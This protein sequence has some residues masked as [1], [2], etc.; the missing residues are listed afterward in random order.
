ME[1]VLIKLNPQKL[2]NPDLD[3]CY[4]L[5]ERLEEITDGIVTDHGYEYLEDTLNSIG[6]WL[7]TGC[8]DKA[9]PLV[10]EAL[11]QETFCGNDLSQ[12]VEIYISSLEAA[13]LQDCCYVYPK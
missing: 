8:A 9:Y 2:V 1:T 10:V 12:A 13:D 11:K 5:P 3:L 4:V 6:I 7:Q